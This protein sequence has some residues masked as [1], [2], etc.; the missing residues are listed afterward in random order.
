MNVLVLTLAILVGFIFYSQQS[1][2][3]ANAM[4]RAARAA[5]KPAAG[6][7]GFWRGVGRLR[8]PVRRYVGSLL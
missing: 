7:N 1:V 6:R 5:R 8:R 2:A 4:S 3:M